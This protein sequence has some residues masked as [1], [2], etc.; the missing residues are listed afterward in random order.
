ME[1]KILPTVD[2]LLAQSLGTDPSYTRQGIVLTGPHFPNMGEQRMTTDDL[3]KCR[4][5]TRGRI[6]ELCV[7]LFICT[8]SGMV[9]GQTGQILNESTSA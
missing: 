7:G 6:V 5:T 1:A 9:Y 8:A 3:L 2:A 4:N